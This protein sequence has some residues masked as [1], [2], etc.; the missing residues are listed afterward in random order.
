MKEKIILNIK[1][2]FRV[3]VVVAILFGL[4]WLV[5]SCNKRDAR[6]T[7]E[8]NA[9]YKNSYNIHEQCSREEAIQDYVRTQMSHF[10][11]SE[12]QILG[13]AEVDI[14]G[15]NANYY[16]EIINRADE[17]FPKGGI[18]IRKDTKTS[19]NPVP[20]NKKFKHIWGYQTYYFADKSTNY[21]YIRYY[22]MEEKP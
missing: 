11:I 18:Y 6:I 17:I 2:L 15:E 19:R 3:V 7:A 13:D 4:F 22:F 9:K 16:K 8:I 14:I 10:K 21:R 1:I 12:T 20:I 5:K